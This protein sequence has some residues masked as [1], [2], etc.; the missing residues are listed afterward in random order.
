MG[1]HETKTL[2]IATPGCL[3]LASSLRR[4]CS[5]TSGQRP[6][7]IRASSASQA[8]LDS[9][10]SVRWMAGS[11]QQSVACPTGVDPDG[12]PAPPQALPPKALRP[13]QALP[14][15]ALRQNRLSAPLLESLPPPSARQRL[16]RQ[17]GGPRQLVRLRGSRALPRLC[18]CRP[19]CFPPPRLLP[20]LPPHAALVQGAR[21]GTRAKCPDL[22]TD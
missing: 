1:G 18:P 22:F 12:T 20:T 21:P 15:K 11:V 10:L 14:P 13:P 2:D 3:L 8:S 16:R 6:S 4:T 9:P 19:P 5:L 7:L 17:G